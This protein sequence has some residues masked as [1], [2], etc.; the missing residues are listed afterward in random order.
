MKAKRI[1]DTSPVFEPYIR[2][3]SSKTAIIEK[4]E[5]VKATSLAAKTLGLAAVKNAA[6]AKLNIG[7]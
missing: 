4:A 1:A 3:A 5:K 2:L 6:V 7:G